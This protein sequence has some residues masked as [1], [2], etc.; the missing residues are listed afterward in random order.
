MQDFRPSENVIDMAILYEVEGHRCASEKFDSDKFWDNYLDK[1]S[2][3]NDSS[4]EK[5]NS[6]EAKKKKKLKK[7]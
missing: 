1:V 5:P 4:D 2:D 3:D 7:A 6:D